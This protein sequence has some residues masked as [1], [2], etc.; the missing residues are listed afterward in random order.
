METLIPAY[1]LRGT[2]QISTVAE[3]ILT[4]LYKSAFP[5]DTDCIFESMRI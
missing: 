5:E 2:P 3:C 1:P 4:D